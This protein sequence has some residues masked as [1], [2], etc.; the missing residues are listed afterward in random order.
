MATVM[1]PQV[2]GLD[3]VRDVGW[4]GAL[5][6]SLARRATA[7]ERTWRGERRDSVCERSGQIKGGFKDYFRKI[8]CS[9]NLASFENKVF[10]RCAWLVLMVNK[11]VQP[12][13]EQQQS[14]STRE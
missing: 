3:A 8:V 6:S 11:Q 4:S 9:R 14:G 7:P 10:S 2:R 1:A 12:V 13:V 5:T